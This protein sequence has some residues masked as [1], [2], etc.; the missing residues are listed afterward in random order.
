MEDQPY[1][2]QMQ[3]EMIGEVESG[4]PEYVVYIHDIDSWVVRT[5]SETLFVKWCAPY[6][7]ANYERVGFAEIFA[8][9]QSLIRW[10]SEAENRKP[11]AN[12]YLSVHRRKDLAR[13]RD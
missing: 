2:L 12:V 5:N 6:L 7:Q 4:R 8:D 13:P 11:S 1:A 3:K 9:G 10:G